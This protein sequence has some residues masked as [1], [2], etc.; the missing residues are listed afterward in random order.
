MNDIKEYYLGL[1]VGTS[2]VGWA[3]T[4]KNYNLVRFKGKDLWG[5]REFEE[6]N[7][8]ADRRS[9][10]GARRRRQREIA[11]LGLIKEYFSDAIEAVDANF[12]IRLE[13]SMYHKGDK[14]NA[15]QSRNSIFNDK[16]YKDS[17]YYRDYPTIFHLRSELI[18]NPEPHDVRLIYLA[19]INMFK[20]RGHFLLNGELDNQTSLSLYSSLLN[21]L[22]EVI[23]IELTTSHEP[24]EI[25]DVLSDNNISKT[26]KKER[27]IEFYSI[28]KKDKICNELIKMLCGLKTNGKT[29]FSNQDITYT[30]TSETEIDFSSL[31]FDDKIAGLQE[32]F[33]DECYEVIASAKLFYDSVMLSKIL[34]DFEFLSDARKASYEKHGQDLRLLKDLYK[35]CL[36]L[37]TYN[38]MFRE[39]MNGSYS[40]Y[41]NSSNSKKVSK[42]NHK[43]RRNFK[44]R[45]IENL[46]ANIKKDLEKVSNADV[47][48]QYIL[49]E[50][51]N[52]NFLSKQLTAVN[53]TIPNQVHKIELI[54]ILE[55]AEKYLPFLLEK[56]ESGLTVSERIVQLFSFQIPYYVGPLSKNSKTGWVVRTDKK[57]LPWNMEQVIDMKET[58]QRFIERM[59]RR[60]TYMTS[61]NVHALPKSSLLYETYSVLNEINNIKINGVRISVELKQEL[62]NLLYLNQKRVTR[63][64]IN[65]FFINKGLCVLP[66]EI[67]GIDIQINNQLS[68]YHKFKK[69]LKEKIKEDDYKRMAEDIV[70]WSTIFTDKKQVSENI[71]EHYAH[72]INKETLKQLSSLKFK[73]WG[74][75]S[76]EFF[77]I[78]GY[79]KSTGEFYS[80]IRMMWETNSNLSELLSES[81]YTFIEEIRKT[82][83][84]AEKTLSDFVYEDLEST[85]FSAPVKRMVW[86]VI[87]ILKELE[88]VLG[89]TPKKVFIEM[90]RRKDDKP[91]RTTSREKK[92]EDLYKK[93]LD[94]ETDW[95]KVIN[96]ASDDGTIKSKKMYLYL[97]QKGKCMYSGER[98]NLSELFTTAYDIDHIYPQHFVKDDNIDNN[99]VLVKKEINNVK[100]DQYPIKYEIKEKCKDMWKSLLEY[101]LITKEKYDRLTS[102]Q[103]LT[104]EQKAHFI[105]RQLVETS[106]GTKGVADI[107]RNILPT[108]S[109]VIYS[110]ASN[111]SDFRHQ[112]GIP[113]SR[114]LNSFH[115]AHDA[116]LNIVV[117]NVYYTKFT[118]NPMNFISNEYD[119]GK[120]SYHLG[121]MYDWD[122]VRNEEVAWI[123]KTESSLGTIEVVRKAL[124]RNTPM[125]TRMSFEKGGQLSD[126]TIS[127][128][129][130]AKVNSYM[131]IKMSDVKLS[132]VEKYGGKGSIT[133][134][135]YF[136]VEHQKGKKVVRTIETVPVYLKDK[137]KQ[138]GIKELKNYCE[139]TLN[140]KNPKI[141]IKKI[142]IQSLI[143]R[144]GYLLN[145]ASKTND[146]FNVRNAV[147]LVLP[148]EWV[149][150]VHK[151]EKFNGTKKCDSAISNEKNVALYDILV[152]K[153][154]SSIYRYRPNFVGEKLK[155]KKQK[156]E[157]LDEIAQ[158]EVL[159]QI[160]KLTEIG[161]EAANLKLIE[162]SPSTG[163]MTISKDVTSSKEFILIHQSVT[164]IFERRIDLLSDELAND[165]HIE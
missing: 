11:R 92:F 75:L 16:N 66:N 130:S 136:L 31:S 137:I 120:N 109:T 145:I 161:L 42:E 63:N 106:Q 107:L 80:I 124:S 53:G 45:K 155:N 127:S 13:N 23:N 40:A 110:K 17:D 149:E 24:N 159:F 99:L 25:I 22:L 91:T 37:K 28:D 71:K 49:A 123:A 129:S 15:L 59:V 29:L 122:V 93:I 65:Q 135:Y 19:I 77:M 68:T 105:A 82:Q 158:I 8:K 139:K 83:N 41:V 44:E 87:L 104:D 121:K 58:S 160:L 5:I 142:P 26:R 72:L 50:I 134:S 150:Y 47:R 76:K 69:I 55:N 3:V 78:K 116:Y 117:G 51:E 114:I 146:R 56:D 74:R 2:S 27:L 54:K 102:N 48:K 98:I 148:T 79:S 140:L 1:D 33:G 57:I 32:T 64:D 100:S 21:T 103:P 119:L 144:D 60:C 101:N 9:H 85:Y 6:A 128:H 163:K 141:L 154:T 115:H 70:F 86:Q 73:D 46:Y 133:G 34:G 152:E 156:F 138:Q 18:H 38:K 62:Y 162:E 94:E 88:G 20:H 151:I 4:D 61:E 112:F 96:N 52:E 147:N 95:N 132:D 111:V 81:N 35:E 143:K 7:T 90:T 165:S 131:P 157:S 97:T 164:G 67:S 10:R 84:S 12:M 126:A 118:Q 36:G 14:D 153:H 43:V 30:D 125:L 108:S 89:A 39:E 113:K